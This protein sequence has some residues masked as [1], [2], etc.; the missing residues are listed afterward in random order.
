MVRKSCYTEYIDR[1]LHGELTDEEMENFKSE[2][3]NNSE[4]TEEID[5]HRQIEA[6]IQE[7]DIKK[8]RENLQSIT[9]QGNPPDPLSG[10]FSFELSDDLSSF[11]EF[12]QPV[13]V[14]DVKYI[15]EGIP[16]LH[17]VQH[18]IAAKENIHYFYKEEKKQ[19]FP[20][21]QEHLLPPVDEDIFNDVQK[22]LA[23]KDILDLR[24]NLT[25]IASNMPVHPYTAQDID[26]YLNQEM[27]DSM[28]NAFQ[29]ELRYNSGLAKDVKLHRK[30]Q[31]AIGETDIMDLRANLQ[32]IRETSSSIP[33]NLEEI[34]QYMNL[35]L[36]EERVISFESEMEN[37]ADLVA[38]LELIK[39][40]D[41]AIQEDE[42]MCL[43]ERLN[44][45]SKEFTQEKRKERSL[46]ARL[47]GSGKM[48]VSI[49]A[50]LV[51]MFGAAEVVKEISW[52]DHST[53]YS[54]YFE[55]YQSTGLLR[56]DEESADQ[57]ISMALVQFNEGK[58]DESLSLF[59]K[60]LDKDPENPVG[61]FYTGMAYQETGRYEQAIYSYQQ[62]IAAKNNLFTEQAEWYTGLCYLQTNDRK[63]AY[64]KFRKIIE[65][66][67]FYSEK[68]AAILRKLKNTED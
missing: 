18:H 20:A 36:P 13:S 57:N 49:A 60:V 27:D 61:N 40:I 28:L 52:S 33:V 67:G 1:F 35:E 22:S 21:S 15:H 63:K 58:Y 66:K 64:G 7:K 53:L 29:E 55:A 16:V 44:D 37:N 23:E 45:V 47:P 32:N 17:L 48:A 8:L 51:L 34:D 2:L 31:E 59:R 3:I 65:N 54:Q 10:K 24:A 26:Q 14:H 43:R 5:L 68:A 42:V 46:I 25:Q 6:A 11:K 30:A 38:E 56:S 62:V 9:A 12:S 19:D 39:E 4:L 50:S 41:S